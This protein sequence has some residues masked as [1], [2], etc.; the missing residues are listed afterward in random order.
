VLNIE[1]NSVLDLVLKQFEI[2]WNKV[3]QWGLYLLIIKI[4]FFPIRIWNSKNIFF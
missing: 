1:R 4:L 2:E 3:P